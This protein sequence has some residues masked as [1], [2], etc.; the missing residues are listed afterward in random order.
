VGGKSEVALSVQSHQIDRPTHAPIQ[1]SRPRQTHVGGVPIIYAGTRWIDRSI[2]WVPI[3]CRTPCL[4]GGGALASS[5]VHRRKWSSD[6][7]LA[8]CCFFLCAHKDKFLLYTPS[9]DRSAVAVPEPSNFGPE[10]I[11]HGGVVAGSSRMRF[12]QFEASTQDRSRH[13]ITADRNVPR[14]CSWPSERGACHRFA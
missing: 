7:P 8:I 5:S 9:I 3:D 1:P 11:D 12:L 13:R 4:L 6:F 14:A 10:L 2:E